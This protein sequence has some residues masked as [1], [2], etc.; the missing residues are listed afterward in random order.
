MPS[1][2]SQYNNNSK[3]TEER[4]TVLKVHVHDVGFLF[5]NHTRRF[6]QFAV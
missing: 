5:P 3:T 1:I 2:Q 6:C 4:V